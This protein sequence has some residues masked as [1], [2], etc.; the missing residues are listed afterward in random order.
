MKGG[1][2]MKR[3]FTITAFGFLL[4]QLMYVV[5]AAVFYG[6][7]GIF[8]NTDLSGITDA[9]AVISIVMVLIFPLISFFTNIASF[10]FQVMALKHRESKT[11]NL[12]MMVV[13]VGSTIFTVWLT[14]AL[15]M[16]MMYA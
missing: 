16:G 14:N 11:K 7:W 5:T 4:L 2:F 10:T 6:L 12:I 1:E 8:E 13:T 3:P 9:M 15:L